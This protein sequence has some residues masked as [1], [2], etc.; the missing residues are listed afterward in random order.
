MKARR[1]LVTK[2]LAAL[3]AAA[4]LL[5]AGACSHKD[6]DGTSPRA[7]DEKLPAL[8][9]RDDTPNLMLTWI[10][11]KGDP[12]VELHP[13]DVPAAGRDLVRVVVTDRE[14]GTRDLF[15]VV[16]L[17]KKR[18]DGSYPAQTMSRRAWEDRIAKRRAELLAQNAPPPP[19]LPGAG[20]A[21]PRAFGQAPPGAAT[22]PPAGLTA[23]IYGASW[24]GPCHE[25]EAYLKS[26]GV[27]VIMKDVDESPA[28]QSEMREKLAKA[29]R[30]GGSIPV[31]DLRGQII[32]GFSR[33]SLDRALAKAQSGTVL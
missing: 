23:I 30:H 7:V 16:D 25:A 22:P 3:L 5:G 8:T 26:R 18:D 1:G 13:A 28:A 24:C 4:S 32:V 19:P 14:E 27:G 6:D 33:D 10:D 21:A 29:G 20:T 2:A 11:E 9:L 15:Y 17:T 31:I 12:H